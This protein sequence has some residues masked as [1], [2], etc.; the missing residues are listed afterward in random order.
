MEQEWNGDALSSALDGL[1]Q[2]ELELRGRRATSASKKE[3]GTATSNSG[4]QSKKDG[5]SAVDT[6]QK[7]ADKDEEVRDLTELAV[8]IVSTAKA[9]NG[10]E[11][12]LDG[13]AD[14]YWQSDGPQPHTISAQFIYKVSISE[15]H[16]FLN[17]DKDESY[18]PAL[19]HIKAGN[20]FHDMRVVRRLRKLPKPV[21][22]VRIPLGD[23]ATLIDDDY[24]LLSDDE[25]DEDDHMLGNQD[26]LSVDEMVSRN[27]RRE[28][29][30]R[31]RERKTKQ[32]Q[33]VLD[34]LQRIEERGVNGK[35]EAL[36]DRSVTTAHMI[37]IIISANH[38]N[39]RDSHVRMIKVLG[40]N[41]QVAAYTPK[42]TSRECQTYQQCQ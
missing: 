30:H 27:I 40:P 36:R 25:H 21:G 24:T 2:L 22:W 9:G 14:T 11:Q 4:R 8:W 28:Q 34:I 18:T 6:E 23:S 31:K 35:L 29:A 37:Q 26:D 13:N 5:G 3:A 20:N 15:V 7:D 42:F 32:R 12:L 10:V 16:L 39:G 1:Q 17:Y 19:I 41:R 38:Q 33:G